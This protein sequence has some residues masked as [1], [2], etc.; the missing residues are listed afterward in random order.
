MAYVI[1]GLLLVRPMSQYDLIKAF[2]AGISLFYQASP[3]SIRRA[4]HQLEAA[5][6]VVCEGADDE[7][8]GRKLYSPTSS[9]RES[10][11]EWML[12]PIEGHNVETP[13][14]SRLYFLGMLGPAERTRVLDEIERTTEAALTE[15]TTMQS[16]I[17]ARG[18]PDEVAHLA[19]Y[20]LATLDYGVHAHETALA[21]FR[22]LREKTGE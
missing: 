21:W 4:L 13:S 9:G 12:S 17:A 1:L 3:G 2:Q 6:H 22:E 8:R 15:L 20:S 7:R 16:Q 14:L 11:R 18:V 10:F 19:T 5:G